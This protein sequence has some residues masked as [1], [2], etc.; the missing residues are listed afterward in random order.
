MQIYTIGYTRKS[1][2][3]FF[4]T[5]KG[6]G[7]KKVIDVRINNTSQLSGFT[8]KNDLAFFLGRLINVEYDHYI[9]LAPTKNLLAEYRRT[10]DWE[11]Y[12]ESYLEL[13][14]ARRVYKKYTPG[15][16]ANACLLCSEPEP[17]RCHRRLAVEFLM[18]HWGR[19][20]IQ[21]VHL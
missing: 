15:S 14:S 2:E 10:R 11:T 4:A 7:V 12:A 5:L 3:A 1:A 21:V 6:A 18:S 17:H 20:D 16:F 9:D 13:L 19:N 8:K